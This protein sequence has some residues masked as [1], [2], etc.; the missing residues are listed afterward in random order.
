MLQG[1]DFLGF[2]VAGGF[3]L[4]IIVAQLLRTRKVSS[5]Q[6]SLATLDRSYKGLQAK[7]N[8]VSKKL[9]ESSDLLIERDAE[10]VELKLRVAEL[11]TAFEA[12]TEQLENSRVELRDSVKKTKDL[13]QDLVE[14]AED[15]LRAEVK[16][17]EAANE[18]DMLQSSGELLD[19][20]VLTEF[21]KKG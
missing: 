4:G 21:A 16:A 10:V 13:R 19:T 12:R 3:L 15:A 8:I 6:A 2:L 11:Q 5:A 7:N 17:R 20:Q 14:H 9:Q 18:L 1:I